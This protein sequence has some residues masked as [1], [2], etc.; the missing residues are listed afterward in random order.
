MQVGALL[1]LDEVMTSRLSPGGLQEHFGITP[2]LTSLGKYIGGGMTFGAFGGRASIM[3]AYNPHKPDALVHGGTFN[4]NTLSM[5]AGA[6]VM[7]KVWLCT[8][9]A[10][11][12]A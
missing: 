7:T 10:S 4:N 6:A 2:D 9:F 8:R 1:I 11:C 12:M 5:S 3:G